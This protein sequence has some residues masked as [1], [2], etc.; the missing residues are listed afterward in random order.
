[1]SQELQ[2]PSLREPSTLRVEDL[3]NKQLKA[4]QNVVL[5]AARDV[6]GN[7]AFWRGYFRAYPHQLFKLLSAGMVKPDAPINTEG[8]NVFVFHAGVPASPLDAK[9]IPGEATRE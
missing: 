3:N 2:A 6:G 1:M 7:P 8:G 9:T 5:S 4:L